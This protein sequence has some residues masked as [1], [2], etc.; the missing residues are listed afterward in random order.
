VLA[1]LSAGL[2]NREIAERLVISEKTTGRHVENLFAKLA[3]H[4]RAEAARIA[5]GAG[6]ARI[7]APG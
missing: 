2:T 5:A 7:P 3:V 4:R 6:L 1:L